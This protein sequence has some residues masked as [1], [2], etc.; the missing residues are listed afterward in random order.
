MSWPLPHLW[1]AG[2]SVLVSQHVKR[3]RKRQAS[4]VLWFSK[5]S[6]DFV[7][8]STGLNEAQSVKRKS[9]PDLPEEGAALGPP[10][11]PT[12]SPEPLDPPW[13]SQGPG[14]SGQPATWAPHSGLVVDARK[15]PAAQT[16]PDG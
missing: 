13:G 10:Q 16:P 1:A 3:G 15:G 4:P 11:R 7:H 9:S 8:N 2:G 12:P 14:H 5:S 6:V